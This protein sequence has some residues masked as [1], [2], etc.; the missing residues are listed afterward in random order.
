VNPKGTIKNLR[1]PWVKGSPSPNPSGRSKRLPIS[2]ICAA[3]ADMPIPDDCLKILKRAGLT[4][5]PGATFAHAIVVRLLTMALSGDP[6]AMTEFRECIEGKTPQ[7][8]PEKEPKNGIMEI[9]VVY[10]EEKPKNS[11]ASKT[12]LEI[13]PVQGSK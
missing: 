2:D 7:R 9:R 8:P 11:S 5:D 12:D 13:V 10:D 4:L 3:F 1:A 6:K